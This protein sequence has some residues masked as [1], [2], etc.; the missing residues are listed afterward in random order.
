L[1]CGTPPD[2]QLDVVGPA[3][4]L[5]CLAGV[6]DDECAD[7]RRIGMVDVGGFLDRIRVDAPVHRQAELL[8]KID[9]CAGG[10]VE[11]AAT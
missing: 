10:H 7:A 8:Q 3:G 9:L 4:E 2:Q 6:L 11:T 5:L 1:D